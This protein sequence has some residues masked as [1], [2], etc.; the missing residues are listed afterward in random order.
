MLNNWSGMDMKKAIN[1]IRRSMVSYVDK[2]TILAI[3]VAVWGR[4]Y[5]ARLISPPPRI[6]KKGQ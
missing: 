1:Y 4:Q 2:L 3:I 6:W 5:N